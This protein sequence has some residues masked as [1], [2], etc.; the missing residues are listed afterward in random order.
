VLKVNQIGGAACHTG[1]R[2]CFF[3]K[4]TSTGKTKVVGKPLFDPKKVYK[5]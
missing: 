4:V 5:K 3:T 1:H 2:S